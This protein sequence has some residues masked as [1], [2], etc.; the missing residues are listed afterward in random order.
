MLCGVMDFVPDTI[1]HVSLG[2]FYGVCGS[3]GCSSE[4]LHHI[5]FH[6]LYKPHTRVG[7][8]LGA[9]GPASTWPQDPDVRTYPN[10]CIH[11]NHH[12]YILCI[13][14][15]WLCHQRQPLLPMSFMFRPFCFEVAPSLFL[16]FC[17][18]PSVSLG[19]YDGS[20]YVLDAHSGSL[21]WKCQLSQQ[22]PI[23]SSPCVDMTTGLIWCGSHDQH[24]YALNV[25]VRMLEHTLYTCT[26]VRNLSDVW[27]C[28]GQLCMYVCMH[29][30]QEVWLV[31]EIPCKA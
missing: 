17:V 29:V 1:V 10:Y 13:G 31:F 25:E 26:L 3:I 7:G 14:P 11:T 22:Q 30:M 2:Y 4:K 16:V 28:V 24:L 23:K 6:L 15:R 21:Y 18:S 8:G 5:L 20:L 19:C 9:Y 12:T 27:S